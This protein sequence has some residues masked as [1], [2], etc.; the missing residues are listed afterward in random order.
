MSSYASGG[1]E[2]GRV[3]LMHRTGSLALGES[4][5]IAV[6]SAPHRAEAFEAARFA[7]DA[8]EVERADLEARGVAGRRRLGSGRWCA[9]RRR[10]GADLVGSAAPAVTA[11]IAIAAVVLLLVIGVIAYMR[12]PAPGLRSHQLP[13]AHRRPLA[14]VS[15]RG[16]G[17]CPSD[18]AVR[19]RR[20]P[21]RRLMPTWT[22]RSRRT[23]PWLATS[24]STS[25]R[26]TRS[27]T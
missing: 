9:R 10:I 13:P 7:I 8:L 4:S 12:R 18:A 22:H 2:T 24:P 17:S 1:R 25:A 27:S 11:V 21:Q 19:Q 14:G 16:D 6:V 5:V 23:S 20:R 3:V 26:R 15:P